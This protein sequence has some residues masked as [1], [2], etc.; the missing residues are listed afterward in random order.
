MPINWVHYI[1]IDLLNPQESIKRIKSMSIEDLEKIGMNGREWA[2]TNYSPEA[3]AK[4]FL[5]YL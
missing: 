5:S 2:L 3:V 1:G 4:L